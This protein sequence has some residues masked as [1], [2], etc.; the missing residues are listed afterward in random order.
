MNNIYNTL[1]SLCVIDLIVMIS[2]VIILGIEDNATDK[3]VQPPQC[4]ECNNLRQIYYN[5][6]DEL[7]V[8]E[9]NHK[10]YRD[11]VYTDFE[12]YMIRNKN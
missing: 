8:G 5:R 1:I 4:L 2:I 7:R 6:L 3:C 10:Q 11:S 12:N 9:I